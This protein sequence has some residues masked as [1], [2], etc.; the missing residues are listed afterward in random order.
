MEGR[1]PH[2]ETKM[3]QAH[4]HACLEP[5]WLKHELDRDMS[6]HPLHRMSCGPPNNLHN[7]YQV[8]LLCMVIKATLCPITPS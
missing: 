6:P 1:E 4:D 5:L 3:T 7:Y 2:Q 8:P